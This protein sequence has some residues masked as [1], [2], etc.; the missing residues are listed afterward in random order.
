MIKE[1]FLSDYMNA[2]SLVK[3]LR[4]KGENVC[5]ISISNASND[6]GRVFH[7]FGCN[8][9]LLVMRFDDVPVNPI[10]R[11]QAR[12]IKN[13][14]FNHHKNSSKE[15]VLVVNCIM[16]ISRSA[17]IGQFCEW[18]LKVPVHKKEEFFP[19]R[20]VLSALLF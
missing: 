8:K 11:E 3:D 9:H 1:V 7:N 14:V 16:G 15:W 6:G 5:W 20:G 2:K 4:N 17:A 10:T 12:K 19:N 13:F 18:K